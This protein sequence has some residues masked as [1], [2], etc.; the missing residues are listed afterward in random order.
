METSRLVIELRQIWPRL[1]FVWPTDTRMILPSIEDVLLALSGHE[2]GSGIAESD[3]CDDRALHAHSDVKRHCRE[4]GL[5][6][7]WAFGEAAGDKFRGMPMNHTVNI[8]RTP[9]EWM[10]IDAKTKKHWAGSNEKDSLI[11]VKF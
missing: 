7:S 6:H 11:A 8:V 3:D 5:A 9:D 2:Y 4:I 1:V 10:F